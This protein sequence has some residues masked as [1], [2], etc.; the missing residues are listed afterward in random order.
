VTSGKD[1]VETPEDPLEKELETKNKEIID[2]KVH[3]SATTHTPIPHLPQNTVTDHTPP[4]DKYLRSVADFRNLQDRT[5]RDVSAARDF[6]ITRFAKDLIDS[7]DNLDRALLTVSPE[8]LSV[9]EAELSNEIKDLKNLYDGLKMTERIMM[10]TMKKH[11]LERFD[12]SEGG[13]KFDPNLHEAIFMTKME[14][15]EDGSVFVTQQ[16]G[17]RLNGRVIRVSLCGV[18]Q[19]G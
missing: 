1:A 17:F 2:L 11:G 14:G 6:A 5:K 10:E 4:Q 8:K 9:S 19:G 12:P 3:I 7:V 18:L 16:K 13:E 15:K